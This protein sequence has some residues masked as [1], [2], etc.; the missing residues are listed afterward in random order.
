MQLIPRV[1]VS[2][3]SLCIH[4][5]VPL[6]V[7]LFIALSPIALP[8]VDLYA[9]LSN[10]TDSKYWAVELPEPSKKKGLKKIKNRIA[11]LLPSHEPDCW[12]LYIADDG[13]GM[14]AYRPSDQPPIFSPPSASSPKGCHYIF[15]G[16]LDL[17]RLSIKGRG[18]RQQ[19]KLNMVYVQKLLEE[20]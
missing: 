4:R 1:L 5:P 17:Q 7:H 8:L 12:D 13:S 11:P 18:L 2:T 10:M 16:R 9:Y 6:Q 15:A 20:K 3:P 19:G 14:I